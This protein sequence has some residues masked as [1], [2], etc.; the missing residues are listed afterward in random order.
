M[1]K[2]ANDTIWI[3]LFN[4]LWHMYTLFIHARTY[5][6]YFCVC[7]FYGA[8]GRPTGKGKKYKIKYIHFKLI[9]CGTCSQL[10]RTCMLE[11]FS[12]ILIHT[13]A[14]P[15]TIVRQVRMWF[16]GFVRNSFWDKLKN[17][18]RKTN[19]SVK[20]ICVGKW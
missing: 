4:T 1:K 20:L 7:N 11:Q 10:Q 5:I 17:K 18:S 9:K 2:H 8:S 6:S 3:N 13:F 14:S 16:G 19:A 12:S 15:S